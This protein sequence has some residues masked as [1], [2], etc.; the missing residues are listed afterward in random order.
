MKPRLL[1][2][3]ACPRCRGNLVADGETLRCGGCGAVYPV[4]DG[5]PILL[6]EGEP[7]TLAQTVPR[8]GYFPWIHRHVLTSL[9]DDALALDLGAGDMALD[10]PN[11]IRMDIFLSPHVDVVGDSHALPF[12]EGTFDFV[13]SLAVLE[14]LRQPF[15]AAEEMRRVLRP[16]GQVYADT[17]FVFPH[18][19]YPHHY[20]NFSRS[21]IE[22]V[23]GRFE[24]LD[25][26]VPP[27]LTPAWALIH[28]VNAYV[29]HFEPAYSEQEEEFIATARKL[30]DFPLHEFDRRFPPD[31]AHIFAAGV[32]FYGVKRPGSSL[33]DVIRGVWEARPDLQREFPAPDDLS[34]LRPNLMH[35]AERH[36]RREHAEIDAY[37][38]EHPLIPAESLWLDQR[39]PL[40]RGETFPELARR[41]D[42]QAAEL[43]ASQS[44]ERRSREEA[45]RLEMQIIALEARLAAQRELLDRISRGRVMRL[46][47]ALRRL[48]PRRRDRRSGTLRP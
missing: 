46:L 12:R 27:Y 15:Q 39:P 48:R 18:H 28:L 41:F 22:T 32:H 16:G 30:L 42:E 20:F 3:L 31:V 2:I 24:R 14:H 37:L 45:E 43:A 19:G 36:G 7:Q 8:R 25:S 10:H 23:F 6:P 38:A 1:D 33:P 35:W 21:G 29:D 13:F 47:N 40:R 34:G 17:N 11:I 26:G 5:T 9:P 4:R 44:R